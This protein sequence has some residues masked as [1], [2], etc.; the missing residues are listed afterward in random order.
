MADVENP[1][2]P[3]GESKPVSP[4]SAPEPEAPSEAKEGPFDSLMITPEEAAQR[5][6]E[7]EKVAPSAIVTSEPAPEEPEQDDGPIL[8]EE[9]SKICKAIDRLARKGLNLKAVIALLHDS[10]P[11]ISKKAIKTVLE[12][13]REL[14]AIYGKD[15]RSSNPLKNS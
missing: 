5:Q 4:P 13:L 7:S 3:V 11:T 9:V 12:G 15:L 2:A 14:P 10:N 8:S 6:A 1:S